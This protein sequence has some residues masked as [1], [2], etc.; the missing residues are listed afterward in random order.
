MFDKTITNTI[1]S[2]I[3]KE[4]Y[5]DFEAFIKDKQVSKN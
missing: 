2:K 1:A 3:E 5:Q 4:N